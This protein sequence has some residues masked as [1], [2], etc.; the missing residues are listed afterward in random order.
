MERKR[1]DCLIFERGLAESREKAKIAVMM[2]N[3]YV[4]G[5][6]QDKPGT[7]LPPDVKIEVRGETLKYVS[8]GGLKLEKALEVFPISLE[9]KT[10]MDIGASTGGF[11][12]CMLQ[13]GAKKGIFHRCGLWAACLEAPHGSACCQSGA[14]KRPLSDS[15]TGAG[16]GRFF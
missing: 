6:K 8:R 13:N 15:G 5:Q 1:L 14:D 2:G 3:T 7:M 11:T 9:G 10:V 16:T 4:N 12:D